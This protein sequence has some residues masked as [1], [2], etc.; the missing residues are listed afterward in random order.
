[1]EKLKGKVAAVTG[2]GSGLGRAMALAFADEGMDLGLADVSDLS[3]VRRAVEAKGVKASTMKVD[4][5][6]AEDVQ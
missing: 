4:V 3:E 1:V 2:A 5:S 6:R